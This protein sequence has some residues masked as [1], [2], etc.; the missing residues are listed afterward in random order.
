MVDVTGVGS[1]V[2]LPVFVEWRRMVAVRTL[3]PVSSGK[4]S[5]NG[6]AESEGDSLLPSA[7]RYEL[8]WSWYMS[9][10][11]SFSTLDGSHGSRVGH[12]VGVPGSVILYPPQRKARRFVSNLHWG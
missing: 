7:R 10:A 11:T 12:H 3:R 9:L 4:G 6:G 1:V 5:D 8:A 2:I